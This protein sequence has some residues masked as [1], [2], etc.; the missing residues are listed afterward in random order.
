[1]LTEKSL[2]QPAQSVCEAQPQPGG[3]PITSELILECEIQRSA[4]LRPPIRFVSCR[5]KN[6]IVAK[7]CSGQ[8]QAK[9]WEEVAMWE[10]RVFF[11]AG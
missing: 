3:R 6:H 8:P 10:R 11:L 1:M 4:P 5:E 2:R 7:P 9:Q